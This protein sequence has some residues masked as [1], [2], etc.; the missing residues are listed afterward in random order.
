M[1]LQLPNLDD[2]NYADLVEEALTLIPT[3]APEWTN[4]N[5]SDPGIT[6]IEL[7]AYLTEM[8]LYRLNR[9][10]DENIHSFLKLLNGPNW[11]PSGVQ[12]DAIAKDVQTTILKLRQ[13]ERAVSCEDFENLALAADSRIAR[14]RCIP[15]RNLSMDFETEREGYI[16]LIVVPKKGMEDQLSDIILKVQS[17][18]EPRRLLSTRLQV[19]GP[20]YL[21]IKGQA[22]V[23]PLPDVKETDLKEKA[24]ASLA[25][26]FDPWVGGEDG[27]G[28]PFGRSIFVSE[29]YQL[30][31]QLPGV[32]Y[33][34]SDSDNRPN[35]PKKSVDL[36]RD[37]A[38]VPNRRIEKDG[39][40][41]GLELKPYELV[42]AQVTVKT[43]RGG[44]GL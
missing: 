38:N 37:E 30:L 21:S 12:P 4:Y 15:R 35:Q 22:T 34:L 2:R 42:K 41:V 20:Q 16:G 27:K 43:E 25:K 39:V 44:R 5:P 3:D 28:W 7:F 13:Q 31:D 8:L 6:L 33:V 19:V 9:V 1:P 40:L 23:V 14:T 11:Q 17:N 18:L 24:E 32:D 10:T 26:Y 29:I 36:Q